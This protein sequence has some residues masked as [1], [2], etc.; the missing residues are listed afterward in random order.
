MKD[1]NIPEA[2]QIFIQI[3]EKMITEEEERTGKKDDFR[4][5]G[6]AELLKNFK[7]QS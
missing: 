2:V 6:I 3:Y 7:I 5:N 4:R 1:N